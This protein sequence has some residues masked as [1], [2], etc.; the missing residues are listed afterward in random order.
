MYRIKRYNEINERI[1]IPYTDIRFTT[2]KEDKIVERIIKLIKDSFDKSR[3]TKNPSKSILENYIE[4]E[5]KL[6]I[7]S[8]NKKLL[9]EIDPY[10][11]DTWEGLSGKE[12]N[13]KIKREVESD[14]GYR[15]YSLKIDD[16]RIKSS[17]VPLKRLW[18]L[19]HNTTKLEREIE[20]RG[21]KEKIK[22][23]EKEEKIKA[24]N[25][26]KERIKKIREIENDIKE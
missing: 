8:K 3:L 24:K 26:E 1:G 21:L 12:I 14:F 25:D 9:D 20:K 11:E 18:R 4:Y 22:D 15:Y 5:Y 10:G 23:K 13:I 7:E 17:R 2:N 16:V 19:L 6:K